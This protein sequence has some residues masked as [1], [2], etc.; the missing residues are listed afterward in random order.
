MKKV[1]WVS[2]I[3]AI[4]LV[5]VFIVMVTKI[6]VY[7]DLRHVK[8]NDYYRVTFMAWFKLIRYTYEIPVVKLQK[9][10]N[11]LLVEE[12][13]R[14]GE[15]TNKDKWKDYSVEDGLNFLEDG[16]Q[17]LEHVVGFHTIFQK[18]LNRVA[19]K[20]LKWHTRV[21][22]GDAALS[23]ILVGVVWSAKSGVVHLLDRYMRLK[24]PPTM[25][26]VPVFQQMWSETIF[27]CII[28]FR[29]GQ[30][31]LVGLRLVKHWRKIPRF[32]KP[33]SESKAHSVKT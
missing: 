6:T 4:L 15:N 32:Y 3:I 2:W 25:T 33:E 19:V 18:F 28:S 26:V 17:F 23:A 20:N 21:G 29:L 9:E 13:S 16:K 10:S 1:I 27:Q 7:I 8:D 30:A 14:V 12:K 22:L 24:N 5:L 11:T 31:I